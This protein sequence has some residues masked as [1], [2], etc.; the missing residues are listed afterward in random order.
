MIG[1]FGVIWYGSVVQKVF[2]ILMGKIH[3]S[4][5]VVALFLGLIF[6]MALGVF[7]RVQ[8]SASPVVIFTTL[9]LLIV[10]FI[11]PKTLFLVLAFLSGVMLALLRCSVVDFSEKVNEMGQ[12][13]FMEE[14]RQKMAVNIRENIGDEKV[15]TLGLSYLLGMKGELSSSMSE[16]LRVVG[17]S[18]IVVAS[19][20]HL[21]IIVEGCRKIF[22]RVSRFAG[23]LFSL[24]LIFLFGAMIGWTPSIM[25]AALVSSLSILMWYVGRKW[26]P[27][28][29]ILITMALTLLIEPRFFTNVGWQLS[30]A[31]YAGIMLIAPAAKRLFGAEKISGIAE[32]LIASISAT[33]MCLPI[34]LYYFGSF[35]LL[36]LLANLLILPTMPLVM[37]ATLLSGALAFLPV[38]AK[39]F[40]WVARA[41]IEFHIL[42]IEW[43][44]EKKMFLF[45]IT[46]YQSWVWLIFVPILGFIL[47]DYARRR[48]NRGEQLRLLHQRQG[49]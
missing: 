3:Q 42:I 35:S 37:G 48:Q 15:A 34:S 25:R 1:D 8:I 26:E 39:A 46:K 18:H 14:F 44:G 12:I 45:E 6:G 5:L 21:S 31:A 40:G 32:I 22:G 24:I 49:Q 13:P 41:M 47:W 23:L 30:F 2:A 17:L 28:R 38:V 16:L 36:G 33:L 11:W 20:T 10:A 27:L 29:L 9:L 43:L 4:F 7:F 19:G